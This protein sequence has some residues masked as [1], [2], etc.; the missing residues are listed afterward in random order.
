M[1]MTPKPNVQIQLTPGANPLA[2]NN[3]PT[4][5]TMIKMGITSGALLDDIFL[6][7]QEVFVKN[8]RAY[9]VTGVGTSAIS[10]DAPPEAS[11][12]NPTILFRPFGSERARYQPGST[13]W[14]KEKKQSLKN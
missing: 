6:S 4:P 5:T 3:Q 11:D 10:R 9:T 1:P 14:G 7:H 13:T 8:D 12:L 2:V